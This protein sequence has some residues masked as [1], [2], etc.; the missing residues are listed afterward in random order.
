MSDL[1]TK[2]KNSK[3]KHKTKSAAIR[4]LKIAESHGVNCD[5]TK[6]HKYA[7]NRSMNCGNPKCMW[8]SNP[9]RVFKERT[10][11]ELRMFQNQDE[12]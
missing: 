7:K 11:Q 3:R 6:V 1:E 4:Q 5:R 9:R 12:E 10:I 2:I 8:C